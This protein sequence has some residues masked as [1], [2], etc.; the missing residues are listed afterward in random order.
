VFK[1]PRSLHE[2]DEELKGVTS[3]IMTMLEVFGRMSTKLAK[4]D[5][6]FSEVLGIIRA[7]RAKAYEAVNVALIETYWAVGAHLSQKVAEAS[8]GKW[9]VKELSDWLL[10]QAP[11]LKGFSASNLWRMSEF[12][13]RLAVRAKWSSRELARQIRNAAFERT[14]L[15]DKTLEVANPAIKK[16]GAWIKDVAAVFAPEADLI[17]LTDAYSAKENPI[18]TAFGG[19]TA[20][21]FGMSCAG[22]A[23]VIVR[24]GNRYGRRREATA[25]G[26]CALQRA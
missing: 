9:I 1:P 17:D 13:L 16:V 5:S 15:S 11:D 23:R 26:I 19:A 25:R 18:Y 10:I 4:K 3:H 12:Y 24:R 7:G 2:I 14:V 20:S 21:V 6:E 8:W 22:H